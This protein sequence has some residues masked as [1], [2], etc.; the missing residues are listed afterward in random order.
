MEGNLAS[1]RGDFA[2]ALRQFEIA[3]EVHGQTQLHSLAS[4]DLAWNL[5]AR[6]RGTLAELDGPGMIE[7]DAWGAVIALDAGD[8][9][10]AATFVA[11]WPIPRAFA[12]H[13]LGH[14]TLVAHMAA[15][16]RAERTAPALLDVLEPYESCIATIGHIGTVG[17]VG[18]A[19]ARIRHLLGQTAKAEQAL[20]AATAL[21]RDTGGL[22]TLLRCRA[23]AVELA[24]GA[25]ADS[26][27][28]SRRAELEAI[29]AE[30]A[31]HRIGGAEQLAR[32]LL[33][34]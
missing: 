28:T 18:L 31:A 22:P 10:R 32:R 15:D 27:E 3:R 25:W 30:A 6:E 16:T 29:A 7:A 1:W 33:A 34:R 11:E 23:H 8:R 4:V 13:T 20:A 21:A 12:W 9:D 14:A 17:A 5:L 19:T 24:L 2:E 26:D